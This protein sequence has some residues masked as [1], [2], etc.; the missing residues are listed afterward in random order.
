MDNA[1]DSEQLIDDPIT[2]ADSTSKPLGTYHV[3]SPSAGAPTLIVLRSD[4]VYHIETLVEC[5][6]APCDPI[7]DD[8]LYKFTKKGTQTF[9]TDKNSKINLFEY[10]MSINSK[11]SVRN[12]VVTKWMTTTHET[13]HPWCDEAADCG[14][15]GVK[16][17]CKTGAGTWDCYN[18]SCS[19]TCAANAC[20]AAGG[21]CVALYP[22]SCANGTVGNA[23]Q[24]SCGGGLGVECC[25]PPA[26]CTPYCGAIGTRSEGWYDGCTKKLI[27]WAFCGGET[28]TCSAIGSKSEGWYSSHGCHASSLIS[29][30]DCSK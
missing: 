15:Q 19:F 11:L 23:N 16:N 17:S 18:N 30:S 7:S 5:F 9:V 8:G 2:K 29:W 20:V 12:T 28:A 13:K 10:K 26:A 27:C 4:G 1:D 24:F 25:L 21:S 14:L 6:M 3:T 22:G